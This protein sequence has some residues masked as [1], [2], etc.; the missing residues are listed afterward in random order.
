[1]PEHGAAGRRNRKEPFR[2]AC[3]IPVIFLDL[4]GIIAFDARREWEAACTRSF[5]RVPEV[6]RD[7]GC[8]YEK[9]IV[10]I[11]PEQQKRVCGL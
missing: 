11:S 6:G 1:M 3:R 2:H 4:T 5:L 10:R 8:G 9:K 7:G